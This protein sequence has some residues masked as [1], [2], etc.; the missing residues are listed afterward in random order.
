[1]KNLLKK[2]RDSGVKSKDLD[3][4]VHAVAS[5]TASSINNNGLDCQ[6]EW[7][8]EQ[9]GKYEAFELLKKEIW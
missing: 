1:M 8:V 9:V 2:C 4:V 5:E 6:I 7:L 3:G